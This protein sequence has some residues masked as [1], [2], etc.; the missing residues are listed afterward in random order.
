MRSMMPTLLLALSPTILS[1]GAIAASNSIIEIETQLSSQ[2][3]EQKSAQFDIDAQANLIEQQENVVK[4]LAQSDQSLRQAFKQAKK[5]LEADYQRMVNDPSVDFSVSQSNYQQAWNKVKANQLEQQDASVHLEELQTAF[6][7][8]KAKLATIEQNIIQLGDDKNRARVQRL[9]QELAGTHKLSVSFTN[10]CQATMTLSKCDE[11]TKELALQKAVSEFQQELIG[12]TTETNLIK[13]NLSKTALNIHVLGYNNKESGFSDGVRYRTQM[14][15]DLKTKIS[16]SAACELLNVDKR[17]CF[18]P[19]TTSGE[20]Y[21]NEKEMAWVTLTVR[22]NLYDDKVMINGVSYGS[23]PVEVMLPIG[24]HSVV[25][26]K[27]GYRTFKQDVKVKSDQSLNA[28]LKLVANATKTGDKFA[29]RLTN[30][31]SAPSLIAI[32][33]GK[34]W[35]GEHGSDGYSLDHA[36]AIGA[37]LVTTKQFNTFVNETGYKTYAEQNKLCNTILDGEVTARINRD[38][39]N[40]GFYQGEDFPIVCVTQRDAMAYT[41]WLSKE[42]GAHYRLPSVE[43][44]EIAAR[45]GSQTQYWWGDDFADHQANTGWSSSPWSN[46]SPS[47]VTAFKNNRLGVY[48][49]VGNVWQWTNNQES[50]AKGGAWNYPPSFASADKELAVSPTEAANYIGFRVVR[51]IH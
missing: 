38:W 12:S 24:Q 34:Y 28:Q 30:G 11:Q 45:A 8:K 37:T 10:Q 3:S 7:D 31:Q 49:A 5:S 36:F 15:V 16:D 26:E 42:T 9:R 21:T 32:T 27:N 4:Q 2:Y 51:E 48:D 39:R 46:K 13:Q 6:V 22:S 1:T 29:D 19:G 35:L 17:L 25:I 33:K 40:P 23:T 18:A 41:Q 14:D 50:I 47:P 44:W 43:E 20:Q